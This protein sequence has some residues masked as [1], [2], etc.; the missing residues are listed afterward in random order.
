MSASSAPG[1]GGEE[2]GGVR[3]VRS[4]RMKIILWV[5]GGCLA[6]RLAMSELVGRMSVYV[7]I[8]CSY[9]KC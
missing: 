1:M 5:S 3:G 4:G 7:S 8:R 6:G 2:G 9:V